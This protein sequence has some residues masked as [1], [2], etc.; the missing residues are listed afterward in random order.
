VSLIYQGI[1]HFL[2]KFFVNIMMQKNAQSQKGDLVTFYH[3]R[4]GK[5]QNFLFFVLIMQG[6]TTATRRPAA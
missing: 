1:Q 5:A 3:R 4:K 2:K 6:H